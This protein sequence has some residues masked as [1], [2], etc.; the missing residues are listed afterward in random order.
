MPV[1]NN[2]VNCTPLL[3]SLFN[4]LT[5]HHQSSHYYRFG[6]YDTC[7]TMRSNLWVCANAKVK[8]DEA[9]A[10]KIAEKIQVR[11]S[12]PGSRGGGSQLFAPSFESTEGAKMP[13]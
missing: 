12:K 7:E 8:S 6:T 4:C 3:D 2:T 11:E 9:E 5:P 1:A 13:D 10:K